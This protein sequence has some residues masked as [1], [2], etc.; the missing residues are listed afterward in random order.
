VQQE[1]TKERHL[2]YRHSR[3]DIF[4]IIMYNNLPSMG[5]VQRGQ[6]GRVIE[7]MLVEIANRTTIGED[8]PGQ[9]MRVW[10][11]EGIHRTRIRESTIEGA[12]RGLHAVWGFK[13]GQ[14]VGIY[15]GLRTETT[16]AYVMA[17]REGVWIDGAHSQ[18]THDRCAMINDYIWDDDRQNCTLG[19]GGAIW[20]NKNIKAGEELFMSYSDWYDWD[21][22]KLTRLR[23]LCVHVRAAAGTLGAAQEDELLQLEATVESATPDTIKLWRKQSGAVRL[24]ADFVDGM[25]DGGL[26][27]T[28]SPKYREG[29]T[30]GRWLARLLSC[31]NFHTQVGFR[32]GSSNPSLQLNQ[33]TGVLVH[34]NTGRQ[35]RT[36]RVN[37]NEGTHLG[38]LT[39]TGDEGPGW[40]V[41]HPVPEPDIAQPEE[42][43]ESTGSIQ[44]YQTVWTQQEWLSQPQGGDQSEQSVTKCQEGRAIVPAG[45]GS[46]LGIGWFNVGSLTDIKLEETLNWLRQNKL[47]VMCLLDTRQ[48][49]QDEA[50]MRRRIKGTLGS[51]I[52]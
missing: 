1:E 10:L 40:K 37:Y 28:V 47:D 43:A 5:K 32:K 50:L 13:E 33:L 51:N 46:A 52:C 8:Y 9:A 41:W 24:L 22:A 27:H 17:V 42:D 14:L 44:D 36:T 35:H 21:E 20:A 48:C 2:D 34:G 16:G 19:Q 25:G 30:W 12:G 49:K 38:A 31:V 4:G 23:Q 29:E 45:E 3:S 26:L 39:M 15:G 18:G 6:H 7:G 11:R